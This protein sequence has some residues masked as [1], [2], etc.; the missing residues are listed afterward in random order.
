MT[1]SILLLYALQIRSRVRSVRQHFRCHTDSKTQ[2]LRPNLTPVP[3]PSVPGPLSVGPRSP[4]MASV[5]RQ[6]R[7]V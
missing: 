2:P 6:C 7:R 5:P 4:V 1:L 3:C